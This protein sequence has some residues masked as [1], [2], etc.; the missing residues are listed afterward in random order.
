MV[1]GQPN[2]LEAVQWRRKDGSLGRSLCL[3]LGGELL[4]A[5][6]VWNLIFVKRYGAIVGNNRCMT[7]THRDCSLLVV[8]EDGGPCS[9]C[10]SW[11]HPQLI[12]QLPPPPYLQREDTGRPMHQNLRLQSLILNNNRPAWGLGRT[13]HPLGYQGQLQRDK[14]H[15]AERTSE[16]AG[17]QNHKAHASKKANQTRYIYQVKNTVAGRI[18]YKEKWSVLSLSVNRRSIWPRKAPKTDRTGSFC[19]VEPIE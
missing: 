11:W 15:A 1:S 13:E 8:D 12:S 14:N 19:S 9:A 6:T 4:L 10:R 2:L 16:G 17:L 3:C 18:K 5:S 7:Y